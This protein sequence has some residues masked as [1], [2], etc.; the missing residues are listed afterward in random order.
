VKEHSG[1]LAGATRVAMHLI[2]SV[3]PVKGSIR[4]N[5][6]CISIPEPKLSEYSSVTGS[7]GRHGTWRSRFSPVRFEEG[8]NFRLMEA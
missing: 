7:T 4:S 6:T 5:S 8:R 1:L 2:Q 3:R